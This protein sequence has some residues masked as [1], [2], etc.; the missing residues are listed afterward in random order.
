M[1]LFWQLLT[2]KK[3]KNNNLNN[4]EFIQAPATN[5]Q[6][7][8]PKTSKPGTVSVLSQSLFCYSCLTK[9]NIEWSQCCF[10]FYTHHT[11]IKI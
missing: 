8:E 2:E 4:L 9:P 1:L 7:K 5:M 6:Q 11:I 10:E 3:F